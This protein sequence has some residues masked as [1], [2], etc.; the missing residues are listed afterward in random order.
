LDVGALVDLSYT[1]DLVRLAT[2]PEQFTPSEAY[3][4]IL[5]FISTYTKLVSSS[6]GC[7]KA[8][9]KDLR[10]LSTTIRRVRRLWAKDKFSERGKIRGAELN[11]LAR[12]WRERR[13]VERRLEVEEIR[14][15]FWEAPYSGQA[16]KAWQY[17]RKNLSGKGGGIQTSVKQ[18]ISRTAWESHFSSLLGRPDAGANGDLLEI[19]LGGVCIPTID[20]DFSAEEVRWVLEQKRNHKAPGPDKLRVDFLQI[21]RYDDTVCLAIANMFSIL[22][23]SCETPEEWRRAYLSSFIRGKA[24]SPWPTPFGA[25][26]L[27]LTCLNSLRVCWNEGSA[28]GWSLRG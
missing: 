13:D 10:E 15:R 21:L 1:P 25:L 2:E 19:E 6:H 27:N 8:Y 23:H 5:S 22:L 7:R 17:A 4:T 28:G 24:I 3:G 12:L 9:S 20:D 16:Y 26:R 18:A 14:R 11:C